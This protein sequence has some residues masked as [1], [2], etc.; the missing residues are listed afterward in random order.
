MSEKGFVVNEGFET[1]P[2]VKKAKKKKGAP[3]LIKG[4]AF[5]FFKQKA[6]F[7]GFFF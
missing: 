6:V 2:K 5:T 3:A 1:K 7:F 4:F